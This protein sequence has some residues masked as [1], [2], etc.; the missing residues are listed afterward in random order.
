MGALTGDDDSRRPDP[1]GA[2]DVPPSVPTPWG[3]LPIPDDVSELAE[4]TADVRRRL[5]LAR[6][7]HRLRRLIAPDDDPRGPGIV[8]PLLVVVLTMTIGLV[9]LFGGFWP[10]QS[11]DQMSGGTRIRDIPQR[12]PDLV[13]TDP[14][15]RR[16]HLAAFRPSVIIS[17]THCVCTDLIIQAATMARRK[18]VPLVL[19]D[20][21]AAADLPPSVAGDVPHRVVCLADPDDRL[22]RSV[23]AARA[24]RHGT[25]LVVLV[26]RDGSLTQVLADVRSAH[27]FAPGLDRL[28]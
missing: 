15:G 3:D 2:P 10:D 14:H 18:A 26:S 13:L 27:E 5:R 28:R 7:R 11:D 20:Q 9:S 6:W 4:E 22:S 8:G 25:A 21:P 1:D 24:T 19:L 16:V 12:L 23:A 17:V